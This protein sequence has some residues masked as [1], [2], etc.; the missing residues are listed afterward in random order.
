VAGSA[1]GIATGRF[2]VN[3]D[4]GNQTLS[5]WSVTPVSGGAL[6]TY[7]VTLD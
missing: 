6:L 4:R 2:A 7:S 5:G 1:L 3:R